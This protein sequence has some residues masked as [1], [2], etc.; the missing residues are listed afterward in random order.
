MKESIWDVSYKLETMC[1][2]KFGYSFEHTNTIFDRSKIE[3]NMF[4]NIMHL[5]LHMN[6]NDG[7][8]ASKF[9]DAYL[10]LFNI[11]MNKIPNY[12]EI[13]NEFCEI[14]KI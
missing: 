10:D 14:V 3:E 1:E 7:D 4:F 11:N 9:I 12:Q 13:F 5:L 6:N 8:R 2:K